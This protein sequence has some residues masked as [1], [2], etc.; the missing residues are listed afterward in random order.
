MKNLLKNK[1]IIMTLFILYLFLF[2]L[3]T[4][5][6]FINDIKTLETHENKKRVDSLITKIDDQISNTKNVS[7]DYAYWDDT[8]NFI[9]NKNNR[10]IFD[11]F[12]KDSS[13]LEEFNLAFMIFV[14]IKKDTIYSNFTTF[15]N[16]KNKFIST[17]LNAYDKENKPTILKLEDI[18]FYVVRSN[19]L[20]SDSTGDVRG[21]IYTGKL[22][23][24]KN[25][26]NNLFKSIIIRDKIP[27]DFEYDKNSNYLSYIKVKTNFTDEYIISDIKIKDD[28]N[29]Q[30]YFKRD[31]FIKSK[32]QIYIYNTIISILFIT[33]ILI[34]YSY[35]NYQEKRKSELKVKVKEEIEKQRKQEQMLIQQSKLA[36]M[37]EMIG[38][39]AHQWRQPL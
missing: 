10:F 6:Y 11:N 8:Y 5:N 26:N 12:R 3:F 2:N 13:T 18:Y 19:I 16:N 22:L 27:K 24:I 39:I 36:A 29:I 14:N 31:L 33:L 17:L 20:R 4:Y 28:L 7:N 21:Y 25:L 9:S 35:I 38:N 23:N 30:T 1:Y 34:I 15:I 32:K 37:G